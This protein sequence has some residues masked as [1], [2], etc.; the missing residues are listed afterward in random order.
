MLRP[1]KSYSLVSGEDK[2]LRKYKMHYFVIEKTVGIT[3]VVQL[4][5]VKPGVN[6]RTK[7]GTSLLASSMTATRSPC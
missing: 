2:G 5:D 7:L 1:L 4:F 6:L 3:E